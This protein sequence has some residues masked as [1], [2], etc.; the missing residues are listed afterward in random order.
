MM[1]VYKIVERI[2]QA[3]DELQTVGFIDAYIFSGKK[4]GL[5]GRFLTVTKNPVFLNAPVRP[6]RELPQPVPMD[7][8]SGNE[9]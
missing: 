1:P 2:K 9:E 4:Q 3:C 6:V 8:F 5:F 7:L